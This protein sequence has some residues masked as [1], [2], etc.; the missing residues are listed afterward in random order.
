MGDR[1]L[2]LAAIAVLV[3][4]G[5]CDDDGTSPVGRQE[6]A[7]LAGSWVVISFTDGDNTIPWPEGIYWHF[8]EDGQCCTEDQNGYGYYVFSCGQVSEGLVLTEEY[9]SGLVRESQLVISQD[10][11]SLSAW[12]TEAGG[13]GSARIDLVRSASRAAANCNCD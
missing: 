9:H 5:A 11:D 12:K 6:V 13:P 2:L 3:G 10:G 1:L 8:K 4:V 7:R